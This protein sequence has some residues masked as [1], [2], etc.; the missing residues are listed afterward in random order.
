MIESVRISQV[1]PHGAL[2]KNSWYYTK[3]LAVLRINTE[4]H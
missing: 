3:Q 1:F 2:M 4:A